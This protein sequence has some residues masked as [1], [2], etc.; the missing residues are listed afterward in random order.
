VD[1]RIGIP[2]FAVAVILSLYK[3]N[4]PFNLPFNSCAGVFLHHIQNSDRGGTN[5]GEGEG[6][7][8]DSGD[9]RG[10]EAIRGREE[11]LGDEGREVML[12]RILLVD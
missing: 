7:N 9:W 1:K 6:G 4:K 10:G 8:C 5:K 12:G 11:F 2:A 3:Y